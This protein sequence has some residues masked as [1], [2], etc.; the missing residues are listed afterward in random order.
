MTELLWAILTVLV[1][2]LMLVWRLTET[3][4]KIYYSL[5]HLRQDHA[6]LAQWLGAQHS[7][8]VARAS[9]ASR[10]AGSATLAPSPRGLT[11]PFRSQRIEDHL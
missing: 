2:G 4:L 3:V 9:V 1:L 10:A 8:Q 6:A 5:G 7:S 11:R